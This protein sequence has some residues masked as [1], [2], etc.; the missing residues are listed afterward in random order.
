MAL[1]LIGIAICAAFVKVHDDEIR[2]VYS[3]Q[4]VKGS[5]FKAGHL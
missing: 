2:N 4:S 1:A 3:S 5:K